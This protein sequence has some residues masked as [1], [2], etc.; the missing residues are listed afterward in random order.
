VPLHSSRSIIKVTHATWS[1]TEPRALGAL[2][3]ALTL[4]IVLLSGSRAQSH[5]SQTSDQKEKSSSV[6]KRN[7][8]PA[9]PGQ[10]LKHGGADIG[11]GAAKGTGDLAKGTAVAAG[12]LVTGH[13]VSA[14]S[15]LGKGAE[16]FGKNVG[17]GTGK[18]AAKIGKGLGGAIKKAAKHAAS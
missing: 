17:V 6:R 10:E 11:K 12:N 4:G 16:G 1:K 9:Q 13:P 14:G 15:S 5:A 2:A 7:K 8:P 3:I 18:G